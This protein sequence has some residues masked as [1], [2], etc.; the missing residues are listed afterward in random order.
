MR[1]IEL[2]PE[3]GQPPL[4]L[5]PRLTLLRGLSPAERVAI[6]GFLHSVAGGETFDWTGTVEV[7]GIEM[8]LDS[9]LDL[10][11]ETADAA[12]IL[13]AGALVDVAPVP[14]FADAPEGPAD[15]EAS[16]GRDRLETE[17][18][19]LADELSGAGA[20]R[21]EMA[22][23]LDTAIAALRPDAGRLLDVADG[24]LGRA[25]RL[26]DRPD[27]WTGLANPQERI[28]TLEVLVAEIDGVLAE[29]PSGD[30]A[31]LAA[32]T[33]T[34][35]AAI[36]EGDVSCPE[37]AA[38]AEAWLALHQRLEGLES[39][40]GATSGGTDVVTARLDA[41]R[42]AARAAEDAASPRLVLPEEH[43]HLEEL[44]DRLLDLEARVGRSIRRGAARRDFAKADAALND[45]LEAIGYPSWAAFRMGNGMTP[46]SVESVQ[47]HEQA[48]QRLETAEAEWAD[49]MERLERDPD[50]QAVLGAIDA[51]LEHA[52][53]LLG[54]DPYADTDDDPELLAG[55]LRARTVDAA[56]LR[57]ERGD[58][59]S[60]LRSSLDEAGAIG[61]QGVGT[62]IGLVALGET[63]LGV[64]EAADAAA[65][66]LLRDRERAEAELQ[67]LA[68]FEGES[69][70]DG[71]EAER[72]AV[73]TA[74]GAVAEHRDALQEVS[75]VRLELHM[76]LATEMAVAEEHDA[77]LELLAAARAEER[78]NG[79]ELDPADDD[80]TGVDAVI[81]AV[82]RG[83]GGPIPLVV[84]LGSAPLSV[85][86]ALDEL[87]EDVQIVVVGDVE[88]MEEW[89]DRQPDGSVEIVERP[90]SV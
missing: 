27:P 37:A 86:E 65:V 76:L 38:L 14:E 57:V 84:L 90:V 6:V 35:R 60:H 89:V 88:G 74:E 50:L 64:L 72:A 30:R 56:T 34:A 28:D 22:G 61:H 82:P 33:N 3:E 2:R 44:H 55:L 17:A 32:A 42:L 87:P 69:R 23:R 29:L 31:A 59:M 4:R 71:L 78:A 43:A 85:L 8:S 39:R 36:T 52:V 45:A 11:G 47:A 54:E 48:Q 58:A 7:H 25:A 51:A 62:E 68:S 79:R 21:R 80:E 67:A 63:W 5:H 49:L 16:V 18:A 75:R 46:V 40:I 41:A 15:A 12:L 77:K 66:R 19:E 9:A 53:A 13:D 73:H 83:T 20:L 81:S 24:D 1:F 70:V 26:A 10:M